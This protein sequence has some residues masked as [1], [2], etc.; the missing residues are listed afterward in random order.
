MPE[1]VHPNAVVLIHQGGSQGTDPA[2][3]SVLGV[4]QDSS[5]RAVGDEDL[6]ILGEG[7]AYERGEIMLFAVPLPDQVGDLSE[8][9]EPNAE[10]LDWPLLKVVRNPACLADEEGEIDV[11]VVPAHANEGATAHGLEETRAEVL[12]L[13]EPTGL[14]SGLDEDESSGLVREEVSGVHPHIPAGIIEG[15]EELFIAPVQIAAV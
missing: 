4:V 5:G 10:D 15:G 11:V 6:G 12:V 3:M 1:E 14:I 13:V 9:G 2:R 8:S 7:T